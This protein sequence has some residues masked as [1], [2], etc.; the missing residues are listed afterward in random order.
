MNREMNHLAI[1]ELAAAGDGEA[2]RDALLAGVGVDTRR[3]EDDYT[4]LMATVAAKAGP[5]MLRLLVDAGA[6]VN[7]IATTVSMPFTGMDDSLLVKI[8]QDNPNAAAS[9]RELQASQSQEP[10]VSTD[11]ALS[12]ALS[13]SD[14]DTVLFLLDC[15][16]DARFCNASNY[17]MLLTAVFRAD[18]LGD[19]FITLLQRLLQLGADPNAVSTYGESPLREASRFAQWNAIRFLLDAGA[20]HAPL[21]WTPLMMA[22]ALGTIDD[23]ERELQAGAAL[24]AQDGM[25]RTPWLLSLVTGDLAKAKRLLVAGSDPHA[26]GRCGE[27]ALM[28]AA[29]R[30]DAP[31]LAWLLSLGLDPNE[32]D[33]LQNAPLRNAESIECVRLLLEHG[34][35]V[36]HKYC[37]SSVISVTD[38]VD[39]ARLLIQH[40]ADLQEISGTLRRKLAYLGPWEPLHISHA[41]YL[42]GRRR[43][44]GTA[45]P[46]RMD[47]PFWAAMIRH[48]GNAYSARDK[49][50]DQDYSEPVWYFDRFGMSI[51]ELPDGRV[52][53]IAGEYEDHYD[54]D[55]CI[56]NDVIVHY[57]DGRFDILG[58]AE[59]I[60][61]PTDFHTATLVGPHVYIIGSLGYQGTRQY[62]DTP[63]FRLDTITFRIEPVPTHGDGPGWI[64][65]HRARLLDQ[66]HIE[67]TSGKVCRW[68]NGAEQ[69]E[70]NTS[71]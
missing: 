17:S 6:D 27:T 69:Y 71:N 15:G 13:L 51:T 21:G 57:P 10:T 36:N 63:V 64:S 20:D 35:N 66:D 37:G 52:L 45:N 47:V 49:F 30:D 23:V 33:G 48:D 68:E 38:N 44:F 11:T 29:G 50:D 4:P 16:A 2:V 1:H 39:V 42:A 59:D 7:A 31:M 28:Y 9:I 60:F 46:E 19:K 12:L 24:A 22:V 26:H 61:P 18:D 40:G 34:A 25:E 67:I 56:Y 53:Q 41:D 14:M 65:K 5:E 58:Y 8:E 54:A 32:E 70:D 55:F 43:R 3:T 62:G